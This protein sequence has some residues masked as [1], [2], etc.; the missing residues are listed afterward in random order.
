VTY[1]RFK[2][3]LKEYNF[4]DQ[5]VDDCWNTRPSDDLVESKLRRAA[6][7]TAPLAEKLNAERE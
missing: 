6:R 3:I 2:E 7:K 4:S 5:Q 1:E